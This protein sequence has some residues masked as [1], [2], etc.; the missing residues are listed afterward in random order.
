MRLGSRA[1]IVAAV[2]GLTALLGGTGCATMRD[3]ASNLNLRPCTDGYATTDDGW[4][5]GVRHY[6]P[7]R[8]DPLKHP[9]VLCHG[10][11]LNGTFWTITDDNLPKQ[12]TER[13]Y[14]VFVVDLR[15]SGASRR[16]GAVGHVNSVIRQTFFLEI[17]A[18]RWT[19][20]DQAL[21]DVPAILD[22]VQRETGDEQVNWV[23]HSLGGMLLFPYLE[24]TPGDHRIA[25][26]VAMG[27]PAILA[28]A[29]ERKMLAA[30]R[31]LRV[32]LGGISTGRAAR[33]LMFGR[34]SGLEAI[35]R[36]YYSAENVDRRTVDRFYGY[37]LED[38]GRG[39]LDQLA[40]YLEKGHLVSADQ[41][42]DYVKKL[43]EIQEPTLF[44]AGDGDVMA[45]R[46]SCEKTYE[47]IGSPDKAILAFGKSEGHVDDY[48]HCDLV[49][50]RN[51]PRE[52]FPAIANW[53]DAHQSVRPSPQSLPSTAS[54]QRIDANLRPGLKPLATGQDVVQ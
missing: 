40:H 9:V 43:G 11:G 24:L 6:H 20:D 44:I 7:Q 33:M 10:L 1:M 49:W 32:L 12:L 27:S 29:P 48:G 39:A 51:A 45:S 53:L 5:L 8:P 50:S 26:F 2:V 46:V 37:T 36:L 3:H 30:N 16:M 22:Y 13:G 54:E 25:T 28:E 47:A 38:P 4:K 42:T 41:K 52:V 14:E 35:D 18:H 34:P 21:H 31:Q 23:G 17:G 19:M 15:G